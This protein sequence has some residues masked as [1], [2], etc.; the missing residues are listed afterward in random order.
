MVFSYVMFSLSVCGYV[1]LAAIL[2]PGA[3]I[4]AAV[5]PSIDG[6]GTFTVTY[7]PAITGV[8]KLQI[9]LNGKS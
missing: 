7:V 4:P 9:K 3:V 1:A 2:S 6:S 8:N 5:V